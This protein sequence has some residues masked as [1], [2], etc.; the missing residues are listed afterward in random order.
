[1]LDM[2]GNKI[3][4]GCIIAYPVR[5]GS[6]LE[7]R[8]AQVLD[9]DGASFIIQSYIRKYT[10]SLGVYWRKAKRPCFF[11]ALERTIVITLPEQLRKEL[12]IEEIRKEETQEDNEEAVARRICDVATIGDELSLSAV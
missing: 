10:Y 8:I 3:V 9:F 7:T 2:L 11:G 5:R 6:R 1:M 4:I 12:G